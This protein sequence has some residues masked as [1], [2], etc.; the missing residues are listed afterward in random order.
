[1]P[2]LDLTRLTKNNLLHI[3]KASV[4]SDMFK[5]IYVKDR[6]SRQFDAAENGNKS[7]A[8]HTS[9]VLALVGLIDKPHATVGTVLKAMRQAGWT[10]VEKPV[11]GAIVLWRGTE[12][13][14]SHSGFYL[15]KDSYVSNSSEQ[16]HPISHGSILSDGR[17]PSK[18]YV[19]P[20]LLK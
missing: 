16:G 3:I 2:N 7:C 18:Y 8:Y 14:I 11:P 5:H 9:G 1:M 6:N 13:Q 19:H 20:E 10:E 17:A 12:N 4:G 15:K